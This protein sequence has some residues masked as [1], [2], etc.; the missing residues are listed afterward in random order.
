MLKINDLKEQIADFLTENISFENAVSLVNASLKYKERNL[1]ESAFKFILSNAEK[2]LLTDDFIENMSE[3]EFIKILGMH[4][5]P[6]S[7][8]LSCQRK[9]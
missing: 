2:I 1:Y 8:Y 9:W 4:P 3:N 7:S 6:F 5:N